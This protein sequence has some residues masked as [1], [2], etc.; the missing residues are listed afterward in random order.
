MILGIGNDL[1]DIRRIERTLERFGDRFLTRVYTETERAKAARRQGAPKAYAGTLAKR[2]A[3]KEAAAKALGTGF[4]QGVFFRDLGVVNLPSGQPT[5]AMTGGAAARLRTLV[6]DGMEARVHLTMT[7]EYPLAEA[8]VIISA[9][10]AGA[11]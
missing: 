4:R 10:P 2:F 8:Q 1:C 6:P 11:P 3:A 7:D 5:I 9:V